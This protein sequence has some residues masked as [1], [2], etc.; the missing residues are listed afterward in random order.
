MIFTK[1]TETFTDPTNADEIDRAL[2]VMK[3]IA[4]LSKN[5]IAQ[6]SYDLFRVVMQTPVSTTYS[7]EKK[8]D[9]S[10]LTMHG[11]NKQDEPFQ[12]V[13]DPRDILT[14]LGHHFDLATGDGENQDEPIQDALCVLAYASDPTTIKALKDFFDSQKK[15]F[16]HGICHAYQDSKPPELRRAIFFF[17]PLIVDRFFDTRSSVGSTGGVAVNLLIFCHV[18]PQFNSRILHFFVTVLLK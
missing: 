9:A 3:L 4:P 1:L 5:G 17:H 6:K 10:R 14:F 18:V 2:E 16:V 11:A 7:Q 12:L 15:S 13:K 8:W